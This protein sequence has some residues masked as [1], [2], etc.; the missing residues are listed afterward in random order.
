MQSFQG[1]K[2][3]RFGA[4]DATQTLQLVG[5][6]AAV[7]VAILV[8]VL[9]A[10]RYTRWDWTANKRYSLSE[11]TV[12]TLRSLSGLRGP[13]GGSVQIWVLLGP[14]DPLGQSIKQ[15]LVAY[16]A[17]TTHLELHYVDPDHDTLALEDV[18]KRFKIETGRTEEGHVVADAIAVI[19]YGDR[20]WFLTPAD[21]LQ[22]SRGDDTKVSPRE[23]QA[24]TGAIRNV[25]GGEK[26]T[27]CF[28]SGHGEMNPLE[29]G[30]GGISFLKDILE[31][32]NYAVRLVDA[33]V[34]NAADPFSDCAVAIVAGMRG[35][36][37]KDEAERLRTWLL[38]GGNLFLAAS[39]ILGD[40]E[41]GLIPAGLD[42]VLLPFGIALDENLVIEQD[43]NLAFAGDIGTRFLAEPKMHSMT[44]ALVKGNSHA[45]VPRV[46]VHFTRSMHRANA[47]GSVA[48][49]PLLSSSAKSFGL[50]SI[51]GASEWT[52]VPQKRDGDLA[53]PLVI[54]MASERPKLSPSAAHGPRAFVIGTPSVLTQSSFREPLPM[55]GGALLV[56][57]AISWL[58][59]KP[60]VLDVPERSAV[61]AGIRITDASRA[62]IQRYVLLLM[63]GAVVLFAIGILLSRRATE[64]KPA[65][66]KK[67]EE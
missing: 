37:T 19:A 10:R 28:A 67:A 8:N 40:S 31:K 6:V 24:L 38:G 22:V 42:R 1:K 39:P 4:L 17:E 44:A 66:S 53:G 15:L 11:A 41:T 18:K 33:S 12:Q 55:R 9:V 49:A 51:A 2:G 56:E 27:L 60:Q 52:D 35:G 16:Q 64:G 57:N 63:P 34:P 36:F 45:D 29:A 62:E 43:S 3:K 61:A 26:V 5:V 47:E 59:S 50:T 13:D 54:A 65:K 25:L 30:D 21:M 58:A 32:D 46:V 20:H 7:V 48:P 14:A 23:E